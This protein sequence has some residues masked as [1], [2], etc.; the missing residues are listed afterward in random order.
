MTRAVAELPTDVP[1][2]PT[3]PTELLRAIAFGKV[4]VDHRSLHVLIDHPAESI[5][6]MLNWGMEDHEDAPLDVSDALIDIFRYLKTPEA[7][8]FYV[9]C[10][11]LQ[12]EDVTDELVAAIYSVRELAVEPL[13][14]LYEEL[15]EDQAGEVAFILA[16]TRIVDGRIFDIL[17]DRL[18]YDASDGALSLGLYGDAA[19]RPALEKMLAQ[20]PAEEVSIRRDFEDALEQLARAVD[21][22]PADFDIWDEY[23]E[24]ALP[25]FELLSEEERLEMLGSDSAEE[26]AAAAE[27]FI[28]REHTANVRQRLFQVAQNDPDAAVRGNCWEA[29]AGDVEEHPEI[30]KPMLARLKNTGTPM[31]E[32]AGALVGLAL[33]AGEPEIK[34]F[35][36]AFY[37]NPKTRSKAMESMYRSFD[38]GFAEYFPRH[39]ADEDEEI[40]R[41][42]I[43]GVGYLGIV[44]HAEKLV[45]FFEDDDLRADA[46][47]SYALSARHET[48]KGRIRAL[49]RKIEEAAGGLSEHE[50]ELVQL[51]LDERLM[52]H[53]QD[54]V[55]YTEPHDHHHD[56]EHN[57][58]HAEPATAAK[59]GRND[60]CTCGSGKKYKK[61][62]GATT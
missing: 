4:A 25:H 42:A 26:R 14:K 61:C 47:F 2:T 27:G 9:H 15:E 12:P 29:L 38:K 24:R 33:E 5:P 22:M 3:N 16:A 59:V 37:E 46:L 52:I 53:G 45:I 51:A 11:R 8:P 31:A 58:A 44:S 57:H 43:W 1:I 21:E 39:L 7:V 55:F 32:R 62:C 23:P 36:V 6:A 34:P 35:V 56:H 20:I 40:R 30:R 17:I 18:E 10:L 41:Q 60:P 13:L 19:A 48:S 49:Y 50:I 54:A 28:N